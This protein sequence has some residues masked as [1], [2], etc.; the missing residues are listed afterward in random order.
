MDLALIKEK[1][2]KPKKSSKKYTSRNLGSVLM[3][4]TQAH[5]YDKVMS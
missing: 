2:D 4:V 1:K 3:F 5:F